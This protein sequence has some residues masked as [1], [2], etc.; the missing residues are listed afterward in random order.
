MTTKNAKAATTFKS[1]SSGKELPFY[2]HSEA[3]DFVRVENFDLFECMLW[4]QSVARDDSNAKAVAL[5]MN[6]VLTLVESPHADA[7]AHCRS[8]FQELQEAFDALLSL[9]AQERQARQS[10]GQAKG[11]LMPGW[12]EIVATFGKRSNDD[13][14]LEPARSSLERLHRH[15]VASTACDVIHMMIAPA[16]QRLNR[17]QK[18]LSARLY[19]IGKTTVKEMAM[20]NILCARQLLLSEEPEATDFNEQPES[21]TLSV[22]TQFLISDQWDVDRLGEKLKVGDAREDERP[23]GWGNMRSPLDY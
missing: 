19:L 7:A 3:K 6:G 11:S 22:A 21:S 20:N 14:N 9:K 5:R 12:E 10:R 8:H 15:K 2:K 13:A 4:H 23:H 17:A 1:R 16:W 18:E